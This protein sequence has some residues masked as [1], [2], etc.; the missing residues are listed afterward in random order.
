MA[1]LPGFQAESAFVLAE[2]ARKVIADG[3]MGI[4][5]GSS[6]LTVAFHI[7]GGVATFPTDASDWVDLLRKADEALY[8]A[9]R[10]GRNRICLPSSAQMVTKTSYYTQTQLERLAALAKSLDK[11]EAFLLREAL[12]NL[13]RKYED[14]EDHSPK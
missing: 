5:L 10:T 2:E 12:D 3:E 8:R 13:L 6:S 4:T 1:V 11:S 7:S 9:K 14:K